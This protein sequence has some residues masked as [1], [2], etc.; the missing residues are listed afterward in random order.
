MGND[1]SRIGYRVMEIKPNSPAV[2]I[3]VEPML[4]FLL[5]PPPET[6]TSVPSFSEYIKSNENKEVE[7]TFFNI[8]PQKTRK[9]KITPQKWEGEGLLGFIVNQEDYK[10][11][12][13]RVIRVLDFSLKSPLYKADFQPNT[14]YIIGTTNFIFDDNEEFIHYI[15]RNENKPIKLF[16]YSSKDYKVRTLTLVP[17]SKWGGAGLLGGNIGFGHVHSLPIRKEI[18]KEKA[19]DNNEKQSLSTSENSFTSETNVLIEDKSA[20]EIK[21]IGS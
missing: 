16:V 1:N 17:D 19:N 20:T 6:S 4:D 11:A 12:N 2:G 13:S 10:A 7:L 3:D 8:A 21:K 14:D 9:C 5:Y 18:Q 15:G